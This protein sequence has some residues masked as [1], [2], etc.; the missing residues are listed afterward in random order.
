MRSAAEAAAANLRG[1]STTSLLIGTGS[2][3]FTTQS[4]KQ[5]NVGNWLLAVSDAD[6]ANYLHGQVT[7]YSGPSLTVNVTNTGGSGTLADWSIY[8]SGT[9]GAQG[10]G[11]RPVWWQ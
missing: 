10:A 1:T 2:K 5:F 3:V 11:C 8:V 7:A 4:G 6:E 9:Q